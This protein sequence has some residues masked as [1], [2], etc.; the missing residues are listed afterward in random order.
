[1]EDSQA[2]LGVGRGTGFGTG[3]YGRNNGDGNGDCWNFGVGNRCE[4]EILFDGNGYWNHE[5]DWGM[6]W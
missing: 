1:M 3:G 4:P 2:E 6:G 5:E